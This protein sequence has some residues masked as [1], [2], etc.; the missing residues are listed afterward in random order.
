VCGRRG[1][2][3]GEGARAT[4]KGAR[5]L[6]RFSPGGRLPSAARITEGPPP[7]FKRGSGR[8]PI[9]VTRQIYRRR[10]PHIYVDGAAYSLTFR[11]ASSQDSLLEPKERDLIVDHIARMHPGR[12]LAFVVMPDHVHLLYQSAPGEELTRTLQ[13]LKGA[14]AHSLARAGTRHAPI[15]QA[16]TFDRV[17]RNEDELLDTW[18]YIEANPVRSALVA[19]VEEFRWSSAWGRARGT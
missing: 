1:P 15:W 2:T 9:A 17:I 4:W 11:L 14:S 7:M 5:P 12:A 13:A 16:E 6:Q 3:A 18:R 10:L 19:T 8:Y